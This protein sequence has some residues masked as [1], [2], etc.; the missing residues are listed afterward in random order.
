M[1]TPSHSPFHSD[2]SRGGSSQILTCLC[3]I[4][5]QAIVAAS[6]D[7]VLKHVV[8]AAVLL[9]RADAATV[10]IFELVTGA[11][12]VVSESGFEHRA[13][14]QRPINVGESVTGTVVKTGRAYR[15]NSELSKLDRNRVDF[16]GLREVQAVLC[17]PMSNCD[18]T[19]GCIT[20]Y[21]TSDQ[22]FSEQDELLLSILAAD[23]VYAVEKSRATA[24]FQAYA[25]R[26]AL[27]GLY[28]RRTW[29]HRME[30]EIVRT[31][32]SEHPLSVLVVDVDGF[33][34]FN[35]LHG[36]LLG[37]KLLYD[38]SRTLRDHS[39]KTDVLGRL[40]DEEFAVVAP[41]TDTGGAVAF[42]VRMQGVI[43]EL[44]FLSSRT[45]ESCQLTCSIG[46]ANFP[47]HGTA[48]DRLLQHAV[49]ALDSSK[50]CGYGR[51]FAG[52]D[53]DYTIVS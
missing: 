44:A 15:S 7:D 45:D 53:A 5:E 47:E 35:H 46:I 2:Q 17:V 9:T 19:F 11:L 40:S 30:D 39:R 37:N 4:A 26:D 20:V 38:F 8:N 41:Q 28:N 43:R 48:P 3:T 23:A 24:A 49:A 50:R 32:R 10:R 51:V 25:G 22:A 6:V 12:T 18:N 52:S 21:R 36:R 1:G 34:E 33:E 42:A 29:I 27:T 13:P 31:R 16:A 14:E